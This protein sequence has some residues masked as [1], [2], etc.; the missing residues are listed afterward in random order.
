[1]NPTEGV[2]PKDMIRQILGEGLN[3]ASVLTWGPD[4]TSEAVLL[5][6]RPCA[7]HTER[8]MHYDLEVSGFPRAMR[9]TSS[10]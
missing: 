2:E 8:I 7:L 10:C 4:T 6:Q 9:A 5:R 1:M 3:I